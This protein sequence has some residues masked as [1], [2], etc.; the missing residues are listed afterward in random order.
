MTGLS[1]GVLL[2][3]LTLVMLVRRRDARRLAINLVL[4]PL[5][6]L[7]KLHNALPQALGDLREPLTKDEEHD[8]EDYEVNNRIHHQ[9]GEEKV[10]EQSSLRIDP[11]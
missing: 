1:L 6:S 10:H 8:D 11:P 4:H 3:V 9:R 5:Q 2:R 7:F